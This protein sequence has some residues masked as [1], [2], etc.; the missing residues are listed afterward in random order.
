MRP[1][2]CHIRSYVPTAL[3]HLA[4]RETPNTCR[5]PTAHI[6]QIVRHVFASSYANLFCRPRSPLPALFFNRYCRCAHP[7]RGLGNK[8]TTHTQHN[9]LCVFASSYLNRFCCRHRAPLPPR[10]PTASPVPT[11]RRRLGQKNTINNTQVASCGD[12]SNVRVSDLRS[13]SNFGVSHRLDGAH[14]GPS[15]S[16][17]WH[18]L[19]A[20]LLMSAGL[21]S[22]IK[23]HDLRRLDAP[24]HVFRGHCPYAL[25]RLVRRGVLFRGTVWSASDWLGY[26]G[27]HQGVLRREGQVVGFGY[28]CFFSL[29]NV[30]PN[31]SDLRSTCE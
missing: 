2:S 12:D 7:I 29:T 3:A 17:R 14:D 25:A 27:V 22:A 1:S 24:L 30:L 28:R 23:L 4:W 16:V 6:T 31:V 19:D 9:K 15:H 11:P 21:D 18:P 20:N 5:Y 10:S 13:P 8:E 26:F